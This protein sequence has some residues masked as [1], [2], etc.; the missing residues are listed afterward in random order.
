MGSGI[1]TIVAYSLDRN[2]FNSYKILLYFRSAVIIEIIIAALVS[3]FESLSFI[4]VNQ[5]QGGVYVIYT[6]YVMALNPKG[7]REM[8]VVIFNQKINLLFLIYILTV[9][10][11]FFLA[12]TQAFRINFFRFFYPHCVCRLWLFLHMGRMWLRLILFIGRF[13][14]IF[15]DSK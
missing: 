1:L 6:P 3:W 12:Q 5:I 15:N 4:Q 9:S 13:V 14:N 11:K 10:C 8:N 2:E 7:V